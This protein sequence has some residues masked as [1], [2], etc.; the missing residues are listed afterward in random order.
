MRVTAIRGATTVD[1]DEAR[2]ICSA[3]G[4]LLAAILASNQLDVSQVISLVLTATPDLRSEFPARGARDAGWSAVPTLC[5]VEID[6]PGALPRC[7]RALVHV[8]VAEGRGVRHV[9]LREA[10]SLRPDLE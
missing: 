8:A 7:I 5:A 2:S 9:Y 10:E 6:V 3:T 1:A 4:E